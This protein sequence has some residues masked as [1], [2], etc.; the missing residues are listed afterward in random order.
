MHKKPLTTS[1][2]PIYNQLP[3][4]KQPFGQDLGPFCPKSCA[5][6]VKRII[7][8][9]EDSNSSPGMRDHTRNQNPFITV[10]SSFKQN[11]AEWEEF[12]IPPFLAN[13]LFTSNRGR[14]WWDCFQRAKMVKNYKQKK[15]SS[16][17]NTGGEKS[18]TRITLSTVGAGVKECLLSSGLKSNTKRVSEGARKKSSVNY[19]AVKFNICD[20]IDVVGAN[21]CDVGE[22]GLGVGLGLDLGMGLNQ[23]GHSP[24]PPGVSE[25]PL[26]RAGCYGNVGRGRGLSWN[27]LSIPRVV[28]RTP[29]P[30]RGR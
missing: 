21:V 6:V 26:P 1:N 29:P 24:A 16:I 11:I 10:V 19:I 13:I 8:L 14:Q 18:M 17:S 4:P 9:E 15:L 30:P 3:V 28:G 12:T 22:T 7:D 5:R 27:P 20:R 2:P 25:V 23:S